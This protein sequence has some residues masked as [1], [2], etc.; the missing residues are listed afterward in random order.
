MFSAGQGP[1]GV[2]E[3]MHNHTP[4]Q[5]CMH[6]IGNIKIADIHA[7]QQTLWRDSLCYVLQNCCEWLLWSCVC[8]G[9]VLTQREQLCEGALY[10]WFSGHGDKN[11]HLS[12]YC[13]QDNLTSMLGDTGAMGNIDV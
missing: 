7:H 9:G 1:K 8:S 11:I 5:E 2:Q 3:T 4:V 6:F 13:N 12:M 10:C